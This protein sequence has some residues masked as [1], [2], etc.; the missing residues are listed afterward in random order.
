MARRLGTRTAE[1]CAKPVGGHFIVVGHDEEIGSVPRDFPGV[2]AIARYVIAA[3]DRAG[4]EIRAKPDLIPIRPNPNI[5]V[6]ASD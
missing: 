6:A 1:R 3:L 5:S 2:R 4:Y